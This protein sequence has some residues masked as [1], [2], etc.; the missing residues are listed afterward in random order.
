M[1]KRIQRQ[2]K[3]YFP[4]RISKASPPATA[5]GINI[6]EA[7][8]ILGGITGTIVAILWLAGRVYMAAYFDAMNIPAFQ[9]NFSVWEYAEAAWSR[10]ILYF[11]GT[12]F[13]PLILAASVAL[14]SL[15]IILGLQRMFPKLQLVAALDG[16]TLQ[17]ENLPRR[18]KSLLAFVL[19]MYF[20]YVLLDLSHNLT[21]SGEKQGR[22]TV[23]SKSYVVEVYSTDNLP[24][25]PSEVMQN[26]TPILMRYSGLRLL[27]FN[28]GKYYL[29]REVD[30]ETCKPLR[31]FI[32]SDGPQV[33]LTVSPIAPISCAGNAVDAASTSP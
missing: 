10:V 2:P 11:L 26:T 23:L 14:A 21:V 4:E 32:V 7:V 24:L 31:V 12:I 6:Q 19:I 25:G 29:F 3:R 1:P 15:V 18:F 13:V 17:V 22:A 33:H 9:I 8:S 28:N 5:R 16:I 27:T 30:Q 20:I